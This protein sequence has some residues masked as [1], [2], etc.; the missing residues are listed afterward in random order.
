[1]MKTSASIHGNEHFLWFGIV[2]VPCTLPPSELL[3]I[4]HAN[5]GFDSLMCICINPLPYHVRIRVRA[6]MLQQG[7]DTGNKDSM[8]GISFKQ[9][10]RQS[11]YAWLTDSVNRTQMSI[12]KPCA[13][14]QK[15]SLAAWNSYI[16]FKTASSPFIWAGVP[17]H[18]ARGNAPEVLCMLSHTVRIHIQEIWVKHESY[19]WKHKWC[20]CASSCHGLGGKCDPVWYSKFEKLQN[21]GHMTTGGGWLV[22]DAK[23]WASRYSESLV[24]YGLPPPTYEWM[25]QLCTRASTSQHRF[26]CRSLDVKLIRCLDLL[27]MYC[28]VAPLGCARGVTPAIPIQNKNEVVSLCTNP[29]VTSDVPMMYTRTEGWTAQ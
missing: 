7:R 18:V 14:S 12:R 24:I 10:W 19:D 26:V 9:E 2:A 11:K 27:F 25:P 22:I 1:M 20:H 29:N 3:E 8:N 15:T 5:C 6:P 4:S 23:L 17:A 16:V 21:H 13:H 28:M